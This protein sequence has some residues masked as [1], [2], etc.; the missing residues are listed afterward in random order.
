MIYVSWGPVEQVLNCLSK[1]EVQRTGVKRPNSGNRFYYVITEYYV[2]SS[3]EMPLFEIPGWAISSDPVVESRGNGSK[4]RK[5]PSSDTVKL[6]PVEVNLEKLVKKLKR[7]SEITEGSSPNSV[8]V[9]EAGLSVSHRRQAKRR[10]KKSETGDIKEGKKTISFPKLLKITAMDSD[11]IAVPQS[12]HSTGKPSLADSSLPK[13]ALDG[14]I[15]GLTP[16]QKGMKQSLD[17]ARFRQVWH[18]FKS[19]SSTDDI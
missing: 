1:L 17:G 3:S 2:S 6:R 7:S 12:K 4:K 19:Y 14:S 9:E 18:F 8:Q 13:N 5:R 10:G 16:L 15:A 11:I